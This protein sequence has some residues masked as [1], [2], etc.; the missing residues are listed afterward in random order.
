MVDVRF[1]SEK[2][3]PVQGVLLRFFGV[4]RVCDTGRLYFGVNHT[5]TVAPLTLAEDIAFL[6]SIKSRCEFVCHNL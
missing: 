4:I 3:M 1:Y 5:D 2:N 6:A